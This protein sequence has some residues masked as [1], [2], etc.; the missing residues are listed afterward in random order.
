MSNPAAEFF[1]APSEIFEAIKS[2]TTAVN[3]TPA[4]PNSSSSLSIGK[5]ITIG[6]TVIIITW[7]LWEWYKSMEKILYPEL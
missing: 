4:N 3:S 2:Q 6:I 7:Q 5:V 1:T